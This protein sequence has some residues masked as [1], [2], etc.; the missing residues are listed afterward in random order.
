MIAQTSFHRRRHAQSLVNLAEVVVGEMK[1][2]GMRVHLDFLA[3]AIRQSRESAHVHPHREILTLDKTRGNVA[4]I[5]TSD[6]CLTCRASKARWTV[7]STVWF[8][9][10]AA[11]MLFKNRI[12]HADTGGVFDC[13]RIPIEAVRCQLD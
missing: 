13:V 7:A 6:H 2:H 5:R 9:R 4:R 10:A 11:I 3:E 1:G 12:I 8:S